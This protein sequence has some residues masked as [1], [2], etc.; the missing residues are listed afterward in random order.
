MKYFSTLLLA[1]LLLTGLLTGA[2]V[3]YA[4]DTVEIAEWLVPWENTRPRGPYVD[5]Q[6]RVWFVGQVGNYL[7]IPRPPRLANSSGTSWMRVPAHTPSSSIRTGMCG[8]QET[9]RP[10]SEGSILAP[11]R[12]PSIRCRIRKREI[13]TR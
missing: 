3:I 4:A 1:L 10:T 6:N 2:V 8:T 7:A 13:L 9:G 11:A 5:N 12:S